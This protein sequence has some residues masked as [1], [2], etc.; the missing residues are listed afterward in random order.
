MAPPLP[1]TPTPPPRP[2]AEVVWAWKESSGHFTPYDPKTSAQIEGAHANGD[3]DVFIILPAHDEAGSENAYRINFGTM[4]QINLGDE[5][6]R[7]SVRRTALDATV[8][9]P[10]R[11]SRMDDAILAIAHADAAAA[12]IEVKKNGTVKGYHLTN[13][14]A[15]TSIIQSKEFLASAKGLIGPFVYFANTPEDCVGKAQAA[16]SL[17]E[18]ALLTAQVDLGYSLV[19]STASPSLAVQTFLGIATWSHLTAAKLEKVGCQSVYAKAPGIINRDEWAVP[20][21]RAP[22]VTVIR[23]SAYHK[24]SST[25]STALVA[26]PFWQWPAWVNNLANA[27]QV[28]DAAIEAVSPSMA[29]SQPTGELYGVKT[30]SA[31]RPVH[32]DGKFMSYAEARRRGWAGHGVLA[33]DGKKGSAH[34]QV[35]ST[36]AG[37]TK[38]DGTPD[39]RYKANR[40]P[41]RSRDMQPCPTSHVSSSGGGSAHYQVSSHPTGPRKADGTPDMRYAANRA[42]CSTSSYSSP[43]LSSYPSYSSPSSSGGG[44]G[45][46]YSYSGVGGGGSSYSG[47]ACYSVSSNP[48][49]PMKSDGTPDM[50]YSANRR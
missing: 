15:A 35:S 23:L 6:K 25:A 8:E 11:A 24:K 33:A 30:N 22:Q 27:V 20:I 47:S 37:P 9:K 28:D 50:R 42:P 39:M 17:D 36:P 10:R 4:R 18:G 31:G 38:K 13:A 48:T 3:E 29:I 32:S 5:S 41:H 40:A 44:G 16:R 26:V 2:P 21:G 14:S 1:M 34:Y 46:S 49:G 7:R 19:V 43:L 12:G 45:S